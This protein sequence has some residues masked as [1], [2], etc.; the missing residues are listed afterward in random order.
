VAGAVYTHGH[1]LAAPLPYGSFS[2]LRKST[3][4]LSQPKS[5]SGGDDVEIKLEKQGGAPL[6]C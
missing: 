1:R 3:L 6:C 4:Y 2:V 5:R